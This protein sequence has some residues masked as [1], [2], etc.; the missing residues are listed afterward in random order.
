MEVNQEDRGKAGDVSLLIFLLPESTASRWA[1]LTSSELYARMNI[2]IVSLD[3]Y[4]ADPASPPALEQAK[5]V[6]E[7]LILTGA[8]IVRDSRASK[9][10]NDRFLDLFEDYFSAP[11]HVLKEDERPELGYQVVSVSARS[12]TR[13]SS[14]AAQL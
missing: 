11:V 2:P 7:S 1:A 8:L 5:N 10:A 14:R 13:L 6:A 9:A 12:R 4:L 3:T